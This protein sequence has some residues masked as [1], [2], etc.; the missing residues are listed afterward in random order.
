VEHLPTECGY[1]SV[2][3]RGAAPPQA[4]H[5][6]NANQLEGLD[7][8]TPPEGGKHIAL[9]HS[10]QAVAAPARQAKDAPKHALA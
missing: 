4:P 3:D 2:K 8:V 5:N 6:K 10:L 7:R 1:L 9:A